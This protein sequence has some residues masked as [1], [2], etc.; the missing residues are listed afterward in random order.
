MQQGGLDRDFDRFK[1][2][3]AERCFPYAESPPF[4][5]DLAQLPASEELVFGGMDVSH[6]VQQ[7][8]GLID[9]RGSN[10]R[11]GVAMRRDCKTCGEIQKPVSVDIPDVRAGSFLPEYG[12]IRSEIG[13]VPIL[14]FRKR[15][16]VVAR[17]RPRD[18]SD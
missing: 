6:R 8:S 10:G 2:R 11:V 12:K 15:R 4:K 9:H 13:H 3:V 1:A 17:A 5:G 16:C 14:V 18:R 7:F